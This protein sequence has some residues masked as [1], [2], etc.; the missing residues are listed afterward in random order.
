MVS[1]IQATFQKM[2]SK[3]GDG[4]D[5]G[6]AILSAECAGYQGVPRRG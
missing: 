5:V 6:D 1:D 4:N 2:K 3:A